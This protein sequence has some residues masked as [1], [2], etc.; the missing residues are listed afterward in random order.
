MVYGFYK[1]IGVN[2]SLS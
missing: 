2:G 1:H